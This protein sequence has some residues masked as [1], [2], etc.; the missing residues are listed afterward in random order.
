[1]WRVFSPSQVGLSSPTLRI[2]NNLAR[3]IEFLTAANLA[4]SSSHASNLRL[5]PALA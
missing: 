3:L 4:Q 5:R 1:M 2:S